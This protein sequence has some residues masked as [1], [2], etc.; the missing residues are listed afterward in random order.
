[1]GILKLFKSRNNLED[2]FERLLR[3]HIDTLYRFA[4]QLCRSQDDAEELVQ[5]YLTRLFEKIDHLES[6]ERL[7]PWLRRGLYNLYVDD[8]RRTLRE[9]TLF[10][11][12]EF[13]D[14]T[15]TDL[16]TPFHQASNRD[17]ADLIEAAL[18]ELNENQRVVVLLHDSEGYSLEELSE[19]LQVPVG[20][21]KS[22]LSRARAELKKLLAME[23]F[24]DSGRVTGTEW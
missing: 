10:S 12:E 22:R 17:L 15:A 6:I 7:S 8:F 3:P 14:E 18:G 1:L 20:T 2:R 21:L 4:Y 9:T 13:D 5:H 16:N 23:P 11:T 24:G 19:I